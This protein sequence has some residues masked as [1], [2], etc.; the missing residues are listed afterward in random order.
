[1]KKR[2]VL[3]TVIIMLCI[4]MSISACAEKQ[5]MTLVNEKSY[6]Q[7]NIKKI[8]VDYDR[9]NIKICEND[10]NSIVLK[11]Y[12]DINKEKYFAQVSE[13]NNELIITEGRRPGGNKLTCRVEIYLPSDLVADIAIHSTESTITS[14]FSKSFK[15]LSMDTTKGRIDLSNT[16]ADNMHFASSDGKLNLSNIAAETISFE[17]TNAKADINSINGKISF[18]TTNGKVNIENAVGSGTFEASSDGVFNLEFADIMGNIDVN[19]K[20]SD[21]NF[22]APKNTGF[23]FSANTKNGQINS[24]YKDI[25]KNESSAGGVVG[26][27]PQYTISLESRNGDIIAH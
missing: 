7:S 4:A 14:V 9:D 16:K 12:M 11:E 5:E 23:K 1:M 2:K 17:T 20:N 24:N 19:V 27:N 8:R 26:N 15:G 25:T 22:E 3:I 10:S 13:K 21:I 6:D 18:K